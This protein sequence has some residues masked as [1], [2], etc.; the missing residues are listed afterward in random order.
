MYHKHK[1]TKSYLKNV[2]VTQFS[3]QKKAFLA[4]FSSKIWAKSKK[5]FLLKNDYWNWKNQGKEISPESNFA[6]CEIMKYKFRHIL[7]EKSQT[8]TFPHFP[9]FQI[10]GHVSIWAFPKLLLPPTPT[11][12]ATFKRSCNKKSFV[13]SAWPNGLTLYLWQLCSSSL[14][15]FGIFWSKSWAK[16][17]GSVHYKT[18]LCITSAY[19]YSIWKYMHI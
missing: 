15:S 12:C 18:N 3:W 4:K 7:T 6:I 1:K 17:S 2:F 11:P 5:I 13:R 19:S 8:F 9:H 14:K 16:T 10:F